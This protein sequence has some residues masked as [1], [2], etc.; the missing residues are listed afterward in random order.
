MILSYLI[1]CDIN[2]IFIYT[3]K[4][5]N[6]PNMFTGSICMVIWLHVHGLM[7][8]YISAVMACSAKD[9]IYWFLVLLDFVSRATVIRSWRRRPLSIHKL[10]FLGNGCM[11]PGQI[12][13]VAPFPPYFQTSFFLFHLQFSNFN[14][15]LALLC[16][17]AQHS[18][19]R[20]AVVHRHHF[21]RYHWVN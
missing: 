18:Y 4:L 19:C 10:K 11:D 2:I 8:V 17:T 1:H 14:I 5:P 9:A 12:L 3:T 16:A 20:H 7:T 21:L 6:F 15:L 13:W